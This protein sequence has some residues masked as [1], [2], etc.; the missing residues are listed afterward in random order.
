MAPAKPDSPQAAMAPPVDV[1][2]IEDNAADVRFFGLL[3]ETAP[4]SFRL[5]HAAALAGAMA[6]LQER[7]ADVIVLDLGLEESTGLATLQRLLA[8]GLRLPALV[9]MRTGTPSSPRAA[10]MACND[11]LFD[12][13][14]ATM[15]NA[16]L[17]SIA[18]PRGVFSVGVWPSGCSNPVTGSTWNVEIVLE[19]RSDA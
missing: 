17:G 8:Y 1:L 11:T 12:S 2:L 16:P 7:Q 4:T 9:V 3:L 18:K 13:W 14:P 15:R 19:V 5:R 6:L 10:S